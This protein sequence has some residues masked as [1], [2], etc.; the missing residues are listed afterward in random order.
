MIWS[1]LLSKSHRGSF[2]SVALFHRQ[3]RGRPLH[4]LPRYLGCF[5]PALHS[6]FLHSS[7]YLCLPID[8]LCSHMLECQLGS[9]S[10]PSAWW[11]PQH[12]AKSGLALVELLRLNPWDARLLRLVSAVLVVRPPS[13][14]GFCLD[15]TIVIYSFYIF[16]R[17]K[18]MYQ[19]TVSQLMDFS[20]SH[21]L[22]QETMVNVCLRWHKQLIMKKAWSL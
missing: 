4:A 10:F 3:R 16:V 20:N 6:H 9:P 15:I 1:L 18:R 11:A 17:F 13:I 22:R 19:N 14:V 12:V 5:G 2:H 7:L 21:S 8:L